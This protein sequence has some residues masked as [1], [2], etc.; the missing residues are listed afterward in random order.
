MGD[1]QIQN[2][3]NL[4]LVDDKVD[5]LRLLSQMLS[6]EGYKVRPVT[7]GIQ[8][9]AAV[10]SAPPDLILLDII[11]PEMNGYEVCERLKAN[12]Q[13]RDIPILFISALG[14]TED[15][16]RAF[17]AGGVDYITK[18]FRMA[19]VSARV[20]THLALRKM[21]QQLW[22]Q[23]VEL[24]KLSE[25]I[26]HS[27]NMVIIT[28]L[29]GTIEYVNPKFVQ[30]TGYE[31]KEALGQNPRILK[32]GRHG[33]AHYEKLWQAI[34]SGQEWHGEFHNKRK[35]GTLY[36]EQASISPIYNAAGRMT[37]F[38]AI[39]EDITARKQAEEELHRYTEH[40]RTLSEIQQSIL[41]ARLPETIAIAAIGRIRQ[42][43]PCQ[44]AMVIA[45][46]ETG[47]L[48]LLA[49]Q[50]SREMEPLADVRIYEELFQGQPLTSGWPKGAEDLNSAS[51]LSPMEQILRE[52]KIRSYVI[53]PLFIQG[54]LVGT[55]HLESSFAKTFTSDHVAIA[56]EIAASLAVAIRQARLYEQAQQE[57][58]E[59]MQAEKTLR[60]RE[61]F[62]TTL[63]E[64]T[65]TA[66]E[67]QDLPTVLHKLANRLGELFGADGCYLTLWDE[68]A[69]KTI[70]AA[71]YG[72]RREDYQLVRAEPGETTMTASVLKA[73]R[74]LI[75]ENV[76]DTPYL[77]PRIAKL[78]PARSLLGLP[79][80]A[81]EQ[82]LGAA[83]VAFNRS[84]RFSQDDV[85]RGEQAAAQ[86]A[87]AVAKA[88]LV[89]QL[90]EHVR[91]LQA[92]N[93]ELDAFAHT[94]AHDLKNPASTIINY[95]EALEQERNT[96][97]DEVE[98]DFLATLTQHA[99]KMTTIIDELLLLSRVR[100]MEEISTHPLRMGRI[101]TEAQKRLRDLI[102]EYQAEITA[103]EVWPVVLGY[104]PW[105]EEVWVN[106]LSNALK[107]GGQPPRIDLGFTI[108]DSGLRS[109][110]DEG[111]EIESHK[112]EIKFW[113]RDNGP[114]LSPEEQAR[115]FT[116]FER[117][118]QT[119]TEGHGLGL[120]IVQRIVQKLG[121]Q[122]GVESEGIPGQGSAFFFT[123]PSMPLTD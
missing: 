21:Q 53:V 92:R 99:R 10:E 3:G 67:M 47:Q 52:A 33:Q 49:A 43:V 61:Q 29:E 75:V 106:Y 85:T 14:E 39:K 120:P 59:R 79:L 115:I 102:E 57:L 64:I 15:K 96:L 6:E 18:P 42:L 24:N 86:I 46:E 119:H 54:Q 2:K 90:Q 50:S 36:W 7:S 98:L 81:G 89:E 11:M 117:L 63:N 84:H 31:T 22:E 58:T 101:V 60:K 13:T 97:P 30:V 109:S 72:Y 4:L 95:A 123:L 45:T 93:E 73:G 74:P 113:V 48:K 111:V 5:N 77:S 103:P 9:L 70:P 27:A 114:G 17:A 122:V 82:K 56:R 26:E 108:H 88:Q 62:L 20:A 116:P 37:H 91:E 12:E 121:G 83:L 55:L 110:L 71:A 41:A 76:H 32:S 66:L 80:I 1:D 112:S 44:R 25:A 107:Y 8:A 118:H 87:L 35:D 34:T 16:V 69:Q 100:G 40:L 94:V 19:E 105:V 65:R 68:S 28:D 38:V 104:G 78:F 51:R 23:N